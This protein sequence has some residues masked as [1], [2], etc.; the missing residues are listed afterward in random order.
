MSEERDA[1]KQMNSAE[2]AAKNADT[3]GK[4]KEDYAGY[5]SL[6]AMRAG[7]YASRKEGKRL[8]DELASIKAKL[9]EGDGTKS[10]RKSALAEIEE[11][12]LP[13]NL[14][15]AA[16]DEILDTAV[17]RKLGPTLRTN[18]AVA[19]LRS[20]NPDFETFEK[21]FG[22]WLADNPS[23]AAAYNKGVA[24]SPENAELMLDGLF[25]K[26]ARAKGRSASESGK[27]KSKDVPK[28]AQIPA[29]QGGSAGSRRTQSNAGPSKDELADLLKYARRTGDPVPLMRALHGDNP[30][31][32]EFAKREE[33]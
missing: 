29:S 20:E 15:A 14:L 13:Q 1:S 16:I 19:S 26:F 17:D 30:I 18:A 24:E 8:A 10:A 23:A 21:D 22:Q 33:R 4:G 6:E 9:A 12:G 5:E 3:Q 7:I 27:S 31:H 28:G 11:L 25:A 32:P 2:D